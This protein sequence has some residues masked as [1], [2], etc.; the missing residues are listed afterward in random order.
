VYK[1]FLQGVSVKFVGD[2]IPH[3]SLIQSFKPFQVNNAQE[4]LLQWYEEKGKD[5]FKMIHATERCASGIMQAIAHF[6][7]GPSVSARDLE[8]PYPEVDTIKPED[9]VVKFY[10]LYEKWRRGELQNS[11]SVM[12]YLKSITVSTQLLVSICQKSNCT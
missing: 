12:H 9:V 10:V 6:K 2:I 11:P 8:F 1:Q 4:E 3:I 7:L 5:N